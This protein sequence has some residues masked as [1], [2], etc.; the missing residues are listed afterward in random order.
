MNLDFCNCFAF[1]TVVRAFLIGV[2]RYVHLTE[3]DQTRANGWNK[4]RSV[5]AWI[6]NESRRKSPI[7]TRRFYLL[8]REY[9]PFAIY[10]NAT[11]DI[12]NNVKNLISIASAIFSCLK[13]C[14]GRTFSNLWKQKMERKL[15][16]GPSENLALFWG[17]IKRYEFGYI[18]GPPDVKEKRNNL[19]HA[20][21]KRL[22]WMENDRISKIML[23]PNR[24]EYRNEI[25]EKKSGKHYGYSGMFQNPKCF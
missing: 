14:F 16:R 11:Y 20:V 7:G 8:G 25:I 3:L 24:Q 9:F 18:Q 6:N 10:F 19:K 4:V 1:L 21:F 2:Y 13:I 12:S 17:R 5:F 23:S 15:E 22:K